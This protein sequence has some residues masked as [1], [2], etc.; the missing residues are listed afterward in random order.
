MGG[1]GDKVP[2]QWDMKGNRDK[3]SYGRELKSH[4]VW[5]RITGLKEVGRGGKGNKIRGRG[6][7]RGKGGRIP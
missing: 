6:K 7:T 1:R 3:D 2:W 4:S 5:E